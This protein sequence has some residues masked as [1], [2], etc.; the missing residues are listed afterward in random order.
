MLQKIETLESSLYNHKLHNNESAPARFKQFEDKTRIEQEI[1]D[2]K[3]Q[4]KSAG[5]IILKEDL[6]GMKRVLR[7]Y[8]KQ[9]L[10]YIV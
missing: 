7:R 8:S 10:Y 1:K 6:K 2:I 4:L 5:E 3:K 9:K